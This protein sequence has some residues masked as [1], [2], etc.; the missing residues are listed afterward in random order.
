MAAEEEDDESKQSIIRERAADVDPGSTNMA[1]GADGGAG[2]SNA[3]TAGG[4]G[5]KKK[6]TKPKTIQ[7]QAKSVA[8]SAMHVKQAFSIYFEKR[9]QINDVYA[10]QPRRY[11]W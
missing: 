3:E 10:R 9:L 5:A 11:L 4:A 2:P 6:A 8:L 7:Q 1:G